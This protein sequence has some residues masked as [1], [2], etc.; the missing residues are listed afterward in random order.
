VIGRA[1][2]SSEPR[3]RAHQKARLGPWHL[4]A[5]HRRWRDA[6]EQATLAPSIFAFSR[7]QS[8]VGAVAQKRAFDIGDPARMSSLRDPVGS[9][10]GG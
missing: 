7:W 4:Q 2:R 8:P 10:R 1:A 9:E 3:T 6:R 5:G